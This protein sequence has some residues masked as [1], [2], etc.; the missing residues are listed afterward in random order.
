MRKFPA[1]GWLCQHVDIVH[2]ERLQNFLFSKAV[3]LELRLYMENLY[4]IV[5]VAVGWS[6]FQRVKFEALGLKHLATPLVWD[7]YAKYISNKVSML[8]VFILLSE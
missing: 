1:L 2:E 5:V 7:L 3:V 6:F 8:R 4:L